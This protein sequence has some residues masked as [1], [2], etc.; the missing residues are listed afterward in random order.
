MAQPSTNTK[1]N[2]LNG[3]D[4]SIG[5]SIIIPKAINIDAITISITRNGK[6]SK[7]PI[8]NAVFNSE[9]INAG[10]A[11]LKGT[12]SF[13]VYDLSPFISENINRSVSLVLVTKKF[14]IILLPSSSAS[15][16]DLVSF[17][18]G[19]IELSFIKFKA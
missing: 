3:N 19:E 2:N 18:Y 7:K 12:D 5:L 10:K 6:K 13:E 4:T 9:V 15:S 11:T 8:W 1:S 16:A 14:L 17:R